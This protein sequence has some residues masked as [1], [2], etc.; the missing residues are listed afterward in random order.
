M[1]VALRKACLIGKVSGLEDRLATIAMV[2]RMSKH[3]SLAHF[4]PY[5]VLFGCQPRLGQN[6][7]NKLSELPELDLDDGKAWVARV[8]MRA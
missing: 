4:S 7:S 5:Y 6:I 2:Y 3:K 1:K 8:T